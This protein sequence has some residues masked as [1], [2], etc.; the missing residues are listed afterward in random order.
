MLLVD[1]LSAV[2]AAAARREAKASRLLTPYSACDT[3]KLTNHFGL[4]GCYR[5]L[6]GDAANNDVRSL[7]SW[8][9]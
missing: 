8:K 4:P 1:G 9:S 5:Y 2:E 6:V 7:T 3:N